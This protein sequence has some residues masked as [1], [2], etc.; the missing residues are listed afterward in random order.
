MSGNTQSGSGGEF[1]RKHPRDSLSR[2]DE[3]VVVVVTYRDHRNDRTGSVSTEE[4][5]IRR[6]GRH[7]RYY[8]VGLGGSLDSV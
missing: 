4:T 8:T 2:I 5:S 7:P 1:T 3:P 6:L